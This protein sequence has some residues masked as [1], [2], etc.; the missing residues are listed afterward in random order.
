MGFTVNQ[1]KVWNLLLFLIEVF[2]KYD[3]CEGAWRR[4]GGL[5]SLVG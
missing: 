5:R 1:K 3:F 4:R 2:A